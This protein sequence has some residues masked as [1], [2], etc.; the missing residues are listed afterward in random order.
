[1]QPLAGLPFNPLTTRSGQATYY[2]ADGSGNCS[3]DASPG[4]LMVAAMNESDYANAWLCGAY[5]QI[6]GPKG[7]VLVRIVDRCPECPSGNI[8]LSREA[9]AKIADMVAGRVPI[10]WRLVSPAPSGPI[11]YQFKDGSSKWWTAVQVRNHRTPIWRFEYRTGAGAFK[12]A[13]RERYNYFIESAGMG[14]GPYTFRVTDIFGQTL[15]DTGIALKSGKRRGGR[16][17]A[18]LADTVI[19]G[20][21][22]ITEVVLAFGRAVAYYP[23]KCRFFAPLSEN[24]RNRI[25]KYLAAAGLETTFKEPPRRS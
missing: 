14:D 9:F 11:R 1:M 5:V 2:D 19:A 10:T 7:S 20:R 22:H 15:T 25:G 13:P 17:G 12:E 21:G 16:A 3:F 23:N 18:V 24:R 6:S 4:D 8:D